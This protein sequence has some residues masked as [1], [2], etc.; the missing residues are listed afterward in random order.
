MEEDKLIIII[1]LTNTSKIMRLIY[2]SLMAILT[3]ISCASK[4]IFKKYYILDSDVKELTYSKEE[5]KET[6]IPTT[7]NIQEAQDKIF[8]NKVKNYN[9]FYNN[10]KHVS[11]K[12]GITTQFSGAIDL[13][14]DSIIFAT[15]VYKIKNNDYNFNN[16]NFIWYD[17]DPFSKKKSKFIVVRYNLS[18]NDTTILN[19]SDYPRLNDRN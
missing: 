12:T 1:F 9:E 17:N 7:K 14:N 3:L 5:F 8:N 13:K 19:V 4:D 10:K 18:D 11:V 16:K 6:F 2:F 15:I